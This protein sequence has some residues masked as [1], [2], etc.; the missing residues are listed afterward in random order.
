[1]HREP[2]RVPDAGRERVLVLAVGMDLEDA[3]ASLL[4]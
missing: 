1:M 3:R 2:D 4:G